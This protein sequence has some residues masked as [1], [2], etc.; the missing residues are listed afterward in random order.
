MGFISAAE[1]LAR[2]IGAL[3]EEGVVV[4][5]NESGGALSEFIAA[6]LGVPHYLVAAKPVVTFSSGSAPIGAVIGCDDTM[7]L[8]DDFISRANIP[9]EDVLAG[10]QSA[11]FEAVKSFKNLASRRPLP[12]SLQDRDVVIVEISVL[13]GDIVRAVVEC[14]KKRGA[15]TV[16]VAMISTT[17]EILRLFP[18][19]CYLYLKDSAGES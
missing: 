10:I 5:I 18:D 14:V 9:R 17:R 15:R 2:R 11:K 8:N 12:P 7:V 13:T 1:E 6:S 4:G 3:S 19:L 16:R